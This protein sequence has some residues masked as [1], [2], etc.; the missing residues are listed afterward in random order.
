MV[1]P[2]KES[3]Q[4]S[5]RAAFTRGVRALQLT[6]MECD[7]LLGDAS[8]ADDRVGNFL[9]IYEL[10]GQLVGSSTDWLKAPNS[11]APFGGKPP[12]VFILEDPGKHLPA[13]LR[14]LRAAY[15]G[16]A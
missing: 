16:W 5:A 1:G 10:A 9:A 2:T 15:G 14:H 3:P 6:Q 11:G 12:I 8:T 4:E 7:S 13:T